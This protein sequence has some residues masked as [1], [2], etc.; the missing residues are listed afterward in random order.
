MAR[1]W[2][3]RNRDRSLANMRAYGKSERG[4]EQRKKR[5][6]K[7]RIAKILLVDVM[8]GK[9]QRCGFADLRCLQF[10]HPNGGGD[11]IR[12]K[13]YGADR[14]GEMYSEKYARYYDGLRAEYLQ[15]P[16]SIVMLCAN[17]HVITEDEIK[18]AAEKGIYRCGSVTAATF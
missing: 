18:Q 16:T 5:R 8:G 1:D 3:W 15:D 14:R 10:H 13:K 12:R 11:D 17:C 7:V 4:Q 9:C 6:E 2:H